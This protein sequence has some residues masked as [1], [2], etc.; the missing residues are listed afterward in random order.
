M[1]YLDEKLVSIGFI[2]DVRLGD[3]VGVASLKGE[4]QLDVGKENIKFVVLDDC[5]SWVWERTSDLRKLVLQGNSISLKTTSLWDWLWL[6]KI[7]I[8]YF[9]VHPG[10]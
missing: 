3:T 7:I 5:P 9:P 4:S 10:Y 1:W 2:C 8:D 6:L